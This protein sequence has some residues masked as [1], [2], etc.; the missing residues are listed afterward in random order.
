MDVGTGVGVG[1]PVGRGVAVSV[2][3]E[4]RLGAAVGLGGRGVFAAGTALQ[5]DRNKANKTNRPANRVHGGVARMIKSF[6]I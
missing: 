1:V 6:M 3:L 4:V 2:G 5:A